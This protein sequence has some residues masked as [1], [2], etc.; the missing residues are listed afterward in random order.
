MTRDKDILNILK[1]AEEKAL[2]NK[3]LALIIHPGAIGDCLLTLPLADYLKTHLT[4]GG[5][6]FIGNTS[7]IDFYPG[8]TCVDSIR[9]LNSIDFHRLFVNP[10]EFSFMDNDPL[11]SLFAPYDLIVSFMGREGSAF[12]ENLIATVYSIRSADIHILPMRPEQPY[13]HHLGRFYIESLLANTHLA[14]P[15]AVF[16]PCR[17][18]VHPSAADEEVG[19]DLLLNAGLNPERPITVFQPGS[20]DPDKCWG[21]DNFIFLAEGLQK[22]GF[23]TLAFLGPAELERFMHG[24]VQRMQAVSTVMHGMDLTA[25]LQI[26]SRCGLFIGNDSGITHLA[27]QMGIPTLALFGP[28][29]AAWYAPLG[30]SVSVRQL[31]PES[32]RGFDPDNAAEVL[33]AAREILRQSLKR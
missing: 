29:R 22:D 7:Y 2:R 32:F 30:P 12:E 3:S 5:V 26:L 20:G 1:E 14:H 15:G 6:S 11:V 8:R 9:S 16:D 23:Q 4:P 19:R 27:G 25:V 18:L 31:K 33:K 17:K 28:T 13:E 21:F 24:Q 10:A